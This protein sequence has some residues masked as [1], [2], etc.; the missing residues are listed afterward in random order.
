MPGY[1]V[2]MSWFYHD[3]GSVATEKKEEYMIEGGMHHV[4]DYDDD[5]DSI[6][7]DPPITTSHTMRLCGIYWRRMGISK[8]QAWKD[9][10]A[11]V[12]QLLV[13]GAVVVGGLME[14]CQY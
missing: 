14:Q 8:Q 5:D 11:I 13:L 7:S 10:A 4:D 1:A 2:Y 3:F 12:N 9:R 6:M